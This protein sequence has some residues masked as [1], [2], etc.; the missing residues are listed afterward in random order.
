M[1]YNHVEGNKKAG[2]AAYT[3]DLLSN[4]AQETRDFD[5]D[6]FHEVGAASIVGNTFSQNGTGIYAEP[7]NSL[8][9]KENKFIE[10]SPRLARGDWFRNNPD[11]LFRFDTGVLIKQKCPS[12]EEDSRYH[13][14]SIRSKGVFRGD[15]QS[16]LLEH[17]K[18][19]ACTNENSNQN[20]EPL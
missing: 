8:L 3:V 19:S 18:A 7:I 13:R 2:V 9:I 1:S 6:P 16:H 15:G 12:F 14:C 4:A 17:M 5:L 10:Q 20:G 11:L